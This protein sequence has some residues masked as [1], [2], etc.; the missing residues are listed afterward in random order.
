MNSKEKKMTGLPVVLGM[1]MICCLLWGSAF[2]CIKIGYRLFDI[3][4]GESFSQI[5]FAGIR[6]FIAGILAVLMGS[7]G[8]KKLLIPKRESIP[9]IFILSL[10]QTVLQYTFFYIGL[11][12]TTGMKSS[13]INASNVFFSILAASLIFHQEKLGMR[14]ILGC[15][16]GFWGVVLINLTS[17][18]D[19]SIKFSG[20]GLILISAISHAFSSA[21]TKKFSA[22][23]NPVTLSGY[24]FMSGGAV[25]MITGLIFGGRLHS[26]SFSGI[27]ILLYL[28]FISAAAFSLWGILLKYNTVSKISVFGFMNPVFGVILSAVFLS[29]GSTAEPWRVIISLI[30]VVLGIVTVNLKSNA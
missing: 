27:L 24:Q 6:F 28:A 10:F 16:L 4:S 29:E 7:V 5:L 12:N 13:I 19:M 9:N 17:G 14:K 1:T 8:A 30:L 2:P 3:P 23:E 22:D 18:A 11:A 20:E 26:V 21:F 25:M 15:L